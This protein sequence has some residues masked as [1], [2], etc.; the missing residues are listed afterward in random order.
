MHSFGEAHSLLH[1]GNG[2]K[3]R[4]NEAEVQAESIAF[5]VSEILG[6]DTSDYSFGYIASWSGGKELNELQQSV[7]IIDKTSREILKW[8]D[9]NSSLSIATPLKAA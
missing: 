9:E 5:V 1:N 4:R 8:I 3:Y 7:A 2:A 6:L